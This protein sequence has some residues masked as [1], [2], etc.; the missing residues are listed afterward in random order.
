MRAIPV[1]H[2]AG[3]LRDACEP[4]RLISM[5]ALLSCA[6]DVTAVLIPA[7]A[8]VAKPPAVASILLRVA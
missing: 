6:E 2:S 7:L 8:S 3:P 5:V 1:N 4:L